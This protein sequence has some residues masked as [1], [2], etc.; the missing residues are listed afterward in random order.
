MTTVK[1]IA[2]VYDL[3][4]TEHQRYQN[5]YRLNRVDILPRSQQASNT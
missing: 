5:Q 2:P 3:S 1:H 4:D